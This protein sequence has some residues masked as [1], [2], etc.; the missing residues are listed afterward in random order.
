MSLKTLR[1]G[2]LTV[3]SVEYTFDANK[4]LTVKIT[5]TGNH[6]LYGN[7]NI[8]LAN[9]KNIN[10]YNKEGTLLENYFNNTFSF[11]R[12]GATTLEFSE[13]INSGMPQSEAFATLENN[14]TN[15]TA[16]VS[17][18]SFVLS[19]GIYNFLLLDTADTV[20]ST[21]TISIKQNNIEGYGLDGVESIFDEDGAADY[22]SINNQ[23]LTFRFSVTVS[24]KNDV[25][26]TTNIPLIVSLS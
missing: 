10:I 21:S 26:G 15:I 20:F 8:V 2:A 19:A 9:V 14:G 7:T 18:A 4:R 3:T 6:K 24:I 13:I 5:T 25:S 16:T 22:P 17:N 12:T 1:T 11:T 23:D